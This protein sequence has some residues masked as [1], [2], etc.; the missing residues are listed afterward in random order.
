MLSPPSPLYAHVLVLTFLASQ[1]ALPWQSTASA[2]TLSREQAEN[3][4]PGIK[5]FREGKYEEASKLLSKVVE[6]D[7]TDH[8]AWYYLGLSLMQQSKE[9]KNASK[10]LETALKLQ[11]RSAATHTGLAYS[12]LLRNKLDEA[13]REAQEALR[14]DPKIADDHYIIGFVY[15][16]KGAPEKAL[17]KAQATIRLNSEFAEGYLLKCQALAGFQGDALIQ[18]EKES[19]EE[20]DI[21]YREAAEALE[22]YL[23]LNPHSENEQIWIEQLESLRAW[24][25]S[26]RQ[27][28]GERTVFT[29]R[30]VTTRARVLSKPEPSYTGTAKQNQVTGTVILR[31]IF[32][33]DGTLKHILVVKGLPYGLTEAALRAARQIRFIPAT[34]NG[35][36]V[37]MYIQIEYNFALY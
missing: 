18:D 22:K 14:L 3:S 36:N 24:S 13:E 27:P 34:L 37:G 33:A 29:A 32:A 11:P 17:E 6:K 26:P 19:S 15:L 20:R 16:R 35:R 5:L 12:Y 25:K 23:E 28:W 7:K 4:A 9:L 31:A 21:R 8:R 1:I 2:Q 30:E 10:A